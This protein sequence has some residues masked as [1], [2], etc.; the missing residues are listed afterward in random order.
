MRI[1]QEINLLYTDIRQVMTKLTNS[2][3]V[4]HDHYAKTI[5]N[6]TAIRKML[7]IATVMIITAVNMTM[8]IRYTAMIRA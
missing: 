2:Q 7:I 1:A 8:T 4:I 6:P 5:R 3:T